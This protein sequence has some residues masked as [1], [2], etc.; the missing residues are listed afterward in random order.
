MDDVSAS[1][2]PP[3]RSPWATRIVGGAILAIVIASFVLSK[4]PSTTP[5]TVPPGT[6]TAGLVRATPTR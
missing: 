3:R 4:L 6:A 1:P 2:S 5:A